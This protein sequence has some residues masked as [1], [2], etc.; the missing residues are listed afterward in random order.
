MVTIKMVPN[1]RYHRCEDCLKIFECDSCTAVMHESQDSARLSKI[2]DLDAVRTY[3]RTHHT[4][5]LHQKWNTKVFVCHDCS[6][7]V[8]ARRA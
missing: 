4:T 7:D 3:S 5:M 1:V 8:K 2:K 6:Q